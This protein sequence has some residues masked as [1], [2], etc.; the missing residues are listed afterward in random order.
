MKS[1]LTQQRFQFE[2]EGCLLSLCAH[3]IFL[4]IPDPPSEGVSSGYESM[5]CE[6]SAN[7]HSSDSSS[8]KGKS[9]SGKIYSVCVDCRQ[10]PL[11]VIFIILSTSVYY[12]FD[13]LPHEFVRI[14]CINAKLLS[15]PKN[16]HMYQRII[17]FI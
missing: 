9:K 17:F 5:R 11:I 14:P 3:S 8:E 1:A 6:S 15:K 10:Y 2:L 7:I 4:T 12:L 16:I 13:M